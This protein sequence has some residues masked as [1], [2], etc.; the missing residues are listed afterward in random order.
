MITL[1]TGVRRSEWRPGG[2]ASGGV[3][4]G[5]PDQS[6]AVRLSATRFETLEQEVLHDTVDAT[7]G[8][9]L[10]VREQRAV[11]D[12]ADAA[13]EAGWRH[14]ALQLEVSGGVRVSQRAHAQTWYQAE[15]QLRLRFGPTL[16]A[17]AGIDP[18]LPQHGTAPVRVATLLSGSTAPPRSLAPRNHPSRSRSRKRRARPTAGCCGCTCLHSSAVEVRGDFSD[19]EPVALAR[20]GSAWALRLELPPGTYRLNV[21]VDG[22][23]WVAPPGLPRLA[24]EFGGA[25][26]LLVI[27]DSGYDGA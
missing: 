2:S 16:I 8:R 25:V 10:T 7:R 21:R 15:A 6:L 12:Y 9:V 27:G 11:R 23:P 5:G 3:R 13:L 14:G 20:S 17:R 4:V 22:G 18:G 24:D 1:A 26:G 19:W